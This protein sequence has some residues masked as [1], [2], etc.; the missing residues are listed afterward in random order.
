M[1]RKYLV[2]KS[3][4]ARVCSATCV[5]LEVSTVGLL[6][7]RPVLASATVNLADASQIELVLLD[8]KRKIK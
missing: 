1:A 4:V 6:S 3:M 2:M 5:Q 8:T 7:R